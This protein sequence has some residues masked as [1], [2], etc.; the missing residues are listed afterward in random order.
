MQA[1]GP[2]HDYGQQ[3]MQVAP[4]IPLP[5]L[6]DPNQAAAFGQIVAVAANRVPQA[7]QRIPQNSVL[8][9]T[10]FLF[11]IQSGQACPNFDAESE[12]LP[13]WES[14]QQPALQA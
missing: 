2:L 6:Q 3:A 10:I 5:N 7:I 12:N 11:W 4:D 14:R 13:L 8:R 9:A 1:N